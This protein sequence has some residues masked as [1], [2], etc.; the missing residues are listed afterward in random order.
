V[1]ERVRM[2]GS[3]LRAA[4]ANASLRRVGVAFALF[5]TAE[6][7]I[8][9]ALLIYAFAHGGSRA[10]TAMVLVQLVPCIVLG[11]FLGSLADQRPPGRILAVGYAAQAI[12]MAA[13]AVAIG[14]GAPSGVVFALAPLT[15]LG[16]TL[17]RPAQAALL[18]AVVR[19]PDELTASNVVSGWAYGAS[20]LVGPALAGLLIGWHGPALAVGVMALLSAGAFAL[21]VGVSDLAAVVVPDDGPDVEVDSGRRQ[22][23]RVWAQAREGARASVAAVRENPSIRVLLSLH[24]FSYVLLGA[25]DVLCVVLAA[26]YLHMGPGGAGYLNAALG[27]G[28]LIAG[29][30]TAFLVGRRHLKNTL[31]GSLGAGVIAIALVNVS[32]RTA[33]ALLLIGLVGL[34]TAVFDVSGRTLLQRSAPSDTVAGLFSVLEALTDAGLALGAVLVQLALALGGIR[35]ALVAPA[36]AAVLLVTVLWQRLGR[37]DDAARVPLVEISL[38]RGIP[39]FSPLPAP[40][41]EGIARELVPVAVPAGNTVF[42][43]GDLGDRYYAVVSG[44]L[45]IWRAGALLHTAG[46]G[47]GFGEIAL[48]RDVPR[49]ATVTARTDASLYAVGKELFI[50]TVTGHVASARAAGR[51]IAD[52]TGDTDTGLPGA[53]A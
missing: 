3:V 14:I 22:R 18:P 32:S 20:G 8:W 9:I 5:G 16:V 53:G 51:V 2:V 4:S 34:S 15:A 52:Y 43:E 28:A 21:V 13:V 47:E 38:L 39:I 37:I 46:R 26:S 12:A 41:L 30:V 7:G 50:E 42:R 1:L 33:P 6:L 35:T 40:A 24:A 48:I 23:G 49:R 44:S 11:P 36:I 31:L 29:F 45:D 27:A 17:T 10:G 19:T 25:V